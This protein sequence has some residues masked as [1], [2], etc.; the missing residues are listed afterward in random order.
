MWD[1][2]TENIL[3][4]NWNKMAV[5]DLSKLLKID[6]DCLFEKAKEIGL[7]KHVKFS[8]ETTIRWKEVEINLLKNEYNKKTIEELSIILKRTE[9]AILRKAAQI[10]VHKINKWEKDELQYLKDNFEY[11]DIN[12]IEKRLYRHYILALEK[13]LKGSA[14]DVKLMYL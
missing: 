2:N 7:P 14:L 13:L 3:K 9:S 1:E 11:A 5:R 10:G 4:N 6:S 8:P 12:E